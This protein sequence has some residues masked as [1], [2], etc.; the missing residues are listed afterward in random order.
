[1]PADAGL[2]KKKRMAV[3]T[4]SSNLTALSS[5][6]WLLQSPSTLLLKKVPLETS[7]GAPAASSMFASRFLSFC[8]LTQLYDRVNHANL[9]LR[10]RERV[11][12][13]LRSFWTFSTESCKISYLRKSTFSGRLSL[14]S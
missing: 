4:I 6:M 5:V 1:M 10:R 2:G 3:S 13:E 14:A 8:R 12:K 11:P 9:Q 7:Y